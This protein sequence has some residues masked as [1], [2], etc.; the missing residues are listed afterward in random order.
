MEFN[1]KTSD[2]R[3]FFEPNRYELKDWKNCSVTA[4]PTDGGKVRINIR[5]KNPIQHVYEKKYRNQ[6]P[7][8]L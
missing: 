4:F 7:I 2:R 3:V 6:I 5:N 1:S 8:W